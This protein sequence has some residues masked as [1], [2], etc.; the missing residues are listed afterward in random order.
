MREWFSSSIHQPKITS[1]IAA[2][3]VPIYW[4]LALV[5]AA[6]IPQV[7]N[8]TSFVGAACILQFSYTFPPVLMV[9]F[10]AQ[11]D[12]ILPEE[13]F[14]PAT[15]QSNRVDHGFK[16]FMRGYRKKFALNT[17]DSLYFIGALATAGLGIYAS[18]IGMHD[19]F[20]ATKI[21]PFTCA[22]PAG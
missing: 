9:G 20:A 1:L 15:G 12:A 13:G 10:N 19:T 18:V 21:T 4:G 2:N 6:A 22:N 17:F 3:T 5:V 14:D 11:K 8:L 7:A 16:R